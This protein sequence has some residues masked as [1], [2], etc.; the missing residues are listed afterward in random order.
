[1]GFLRLC[2]L[3]AVMGVLGAACGGASDPGLAGGE[4]GGDG[5]EGGRGDG[6]AGP[7]STANDGA[8]SDAP[9]ETASESAADSP[10][11][12]V[13]DV[14]ASDAPGDGAA[15][16]CPDVSGLYNMS[17]VDATGCGDLN[18]LALEC[19]KQSTCSIVFQSRVTAAGSGI[20]GDPALQSD[21]SFANGALKEGTSSRSGC[22]GT[23]DGSTSTMTVDCGGKGSSQSCVVAL[24]RKAGKCP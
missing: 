9:M 2:G 7:D 16:P 8:S 19:I 1:M 4:G 10:A 3:M 11:D 17:A 6:G 23:W 21:G 5:G 13:A 22:A 14:Q 18:L 24:T 20:D 12:V 15:V